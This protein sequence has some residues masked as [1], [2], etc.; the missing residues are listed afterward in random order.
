[1]RDVH[2]V[3]LPARALRYERADVRGSDDD[4]FFFYHIYAGVWFSAVV[5][6]G[7][8]PRGAAG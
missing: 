2:L 5:G 7:R 3:Y 6:P 1:M 4:V 8:V